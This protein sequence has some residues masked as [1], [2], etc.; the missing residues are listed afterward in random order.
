MAGEDKELYTY[1]RTC[2]KC[3]GKSIKTTNTEV[4]KMGQVYR[5]KFCLDCGYIFSTVE[6]EKHMSDVDGLLQEIEKLK[7]E[8]VVLKTRLDS[9]KDYVRRV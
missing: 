9:I 1:V 7:T 8:N 3:G 5:R 6:T 4:R 2:F